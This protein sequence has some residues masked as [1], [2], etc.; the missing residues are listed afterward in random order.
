[1]KTEIRR[2]ELTASEFDWNF[3]D[4]KTIAAWGF[5]ESV[6]GPVI[7]AKKGDTVVVSVKNKLKAP[8]IIHWH[9]IRLAAPMDG[10]DLVQK[11]IQPGEESWSEKQSKNCV[12]T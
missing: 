4:E 9:G 11:P 7:R 6:P 5:N 1:M 10:T 3:T 8:T 12:D 2:Y